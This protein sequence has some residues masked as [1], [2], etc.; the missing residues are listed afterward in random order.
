ML[1]NAGINP[2]QAIALSQ[3]SLGT[4]ITHRVFLCLWILHA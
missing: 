4:Y 3:N 2:A 1:L